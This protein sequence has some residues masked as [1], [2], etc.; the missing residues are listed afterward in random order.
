MKRILLLAALSTSFPGF[1]ESCA[2]TWIFGGGSP[3]TVRYAGNNALIGYDSNTNQSYPFTY[4]GTADQTIESK[5]N[6]PNEADRQFAKWIACH[7]NKEK[8]LV[9]TNI[10][11]KASSSKQK[12]GDEKSVRN[13]D[14]Q[15]DEITPQVPGCPKY[16][17]KSLV[18]FMRSDKNTNTWILKNVSNK[19]VKVTFVDG[20]TNND[21]TTLPPGD[22]QEIK[23]TDSEIPRYVVRDFREIMD[24][25][26]RHAATK[27]LQVKSLN[28]SLAIRPR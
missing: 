15:L 6:S 7:R 28:C 26:S 16:L 18:S 21:S 4:D 12:S 5:R 19:T 27:E 14:Q 22:A 20:G 23:L 10:N 17:R 25:N 1:A 13:D 24:F 3:V 11:P 8:E 2:P 9:A